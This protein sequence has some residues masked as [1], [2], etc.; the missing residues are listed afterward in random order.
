MTKTLKGLNGIR[1]ISIL[2]VLLY[3]IKIKSIPYLKITSELNILFDGNFGVHVFFVLSGFLI[4]Y[5]LLF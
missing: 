4:T 5:L 3:H 1:G 2:I